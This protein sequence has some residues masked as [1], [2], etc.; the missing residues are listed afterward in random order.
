MS[1]T[2]QAEWLECVDTRARH[3]AWSHDP[4]LVAPESMTGGLGAIEKAL[5]VDSLDTEDHPGLAARVLRE[6]ASLADGDYGRV[7]L[8]V[9]NTVDRA[10]QTY[11][12]LRTL[13]P[14]QEIRLVHG[15][16]RPHERSNWREAFLNREACCRGVDRIVVAGRRAVSG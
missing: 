16:F 13:A 15:R 12:E 2:L 1:A 6:H 7:T 10:S 11:D 9:C 5:A 8:L 14:Y 3:S 4:T